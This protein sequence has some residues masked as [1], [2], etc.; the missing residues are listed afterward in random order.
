MM[1]RN[2]DSVM[3]KVYL[4]LE[5]NLKTENSKLLGV[6]ASRKLALQVMDEQMDIYEEQRAYKIEVKLVG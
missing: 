2:G 6:Y 3:K 5:K 4:L 1:K